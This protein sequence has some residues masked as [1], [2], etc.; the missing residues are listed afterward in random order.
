MSE[1]KYSYDEIEAM[2]AALRRS[3]PYREKYWWSSG[4]DSKLWRDLREHNSAIDRRIEDEVRT[5][6]VAGVDPDEAVTGID[7]ATA[8]QA[9]QQR[10]KQEERKKQMADRDAARAA[11]DREEKEKAAVA[12]SAPIPAT[13]APERRGFWTRVWGD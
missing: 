4:D 6:M 10:I 2:R 8:K 11:R 5:L 3:Y 12:K 7:E 1:R 9:E 13:W